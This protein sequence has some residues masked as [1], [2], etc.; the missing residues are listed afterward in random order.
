MSKRGVGNVDNHA[1]VG[2]QTIINIQNMTGNIGTPD[3]KSESVNTVAL[4]AFD[5]QVNDLDG[6]MKGIVDTLGKDA[7][8]Q[9]SKD[10]WQEFYLSLQDTVRYG[11]AQSDATGE[12][13][14]FVN[15]ITS[16]YKDWEEIMI[17]RSDNLPVDNAADVFGRIIKETDSYLFFRNVLNEPTELNAAKSKPNFE[18]YLKKAKEKY[19]TIKTLLYSDQPKPFYDFYVCNDIE[20]RIPVPSKFGS[21]YRI[22]TIGNVTVKSLTECSRFVILAGTGGLGKS[23]MMR[24]LLLN[25]IENYTEM[26]IIPVFIPLKDFDENVESLFDG[27]LYN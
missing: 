18:L 23:M 19:S 3:K 21:S 9:A 16:L 7:T 6:I 2:N 13:K 4:G 15:N 26:L 5:Q 8:R 25:S 14:T 20:R 10:E 11:R 24:H 17:R 12:L 27:G 22:A 1:N